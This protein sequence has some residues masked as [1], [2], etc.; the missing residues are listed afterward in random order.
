MSIIMKK[1][2]WKN[3][4]STG[5]NYSEIILNKHKTTSI[6]G[7]N[8]SGKT[9]MLDAIVFALFG[10]PYRNINIP[11][12][13]NSINKKDCIVELYFD[14]G[15]KPYV[16]RRGISP[17]VFE[18]YQDGKLID[19]DSTT[20]DYQ[21]MFEDQILKMSFKS[22]CQVV[23]LGSTNYIPFMR[24][25][26]AERRS[27]V[28]NLLDINVFS[29]MNSVLK[30]NMS[31]LKDS[32]IN[33]N[34]KMEVLR[35]KTELQ[36]NHIDILKKKQDKHHEDQIAKKKELML[37]REE[38]KEKIE[39]TE[40]KISELT[41]KT[42]KKQEVEKELN[43]LFSELM[44]LE[45]TVTKNNKE[46]KF[47][48]DATTCHF[49]T[50]TINEQTKNKLIS[51][52]N[53]EIKHTCLQSD[54]I[55]RKV[56]MLKKQIDEINK[57]SKECLELSN[58][59]NEL[60]SSCKAINKL[61]LSLENEINSNAIDKTDIETAQAKMG[62]FIKEG[63]LLVDEKQKILDDTHYA[64]IAYVLLKDSGIKSKII[65]HYL[66]I[67]NKVINKYLSEMNFFVQFELDEEFKESIKSRNRDI[68]SYE[69]F[70]EGEKR[71]I[72]LALLFA[73]RKISQVKNSLSCN[74]LI[75]DEILDGSLDDSATKLL[76]NIL[77]IMDK[78]SNIF[79][80]S[81]K[82][83]DILQDKFEHNIMFTKK[84]NFSKAIHE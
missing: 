48:E 50:Q 76:L 36:K 81:H 72:D 71:K 75:F 6:S 65:K 38:L 67:M 33:T 46:I 7:E 13:V 26:A 37:Q 41:A 49:C 82:S 60:N 19:Q 83:K 18:I 69:N 56:N 12:L 23:I 74:L 44:I 54:Q 17:K 30:G 21:K 68:F 73:W 34:N 45:K 24:L 20:K 25:T 22:F 64:N 59:C 4:L 43:S 42:S 78:N 70:S 39:K 58:E 51:D 10:R 16:V 3:F 14:I 40:Q 31:I 2:R 47:I 57:I 55:E 11:Q 8:G 9:T 84:K 52:K 32:L 61:I 77:Q 79:V 53:N 1:V 29:T 63:K 62:D 35:E 27:V 80:I 5:N 15:K 28:E 66:P